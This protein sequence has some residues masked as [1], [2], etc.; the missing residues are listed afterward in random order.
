MVLVL[1][2]FPLIIIYL[3]TIH[4]YGQISPNGR[5][6]IDRENN[7]KILFSTAPEQP[8]VGTLSILR[9]AVQDL[10]TGKPIANLFAHVLI[11]GANSTNQEAT[12]Q[13]N[14][15]SAVDGDFSINVIFRDK[16][17][18]Q[19]ITKITSSSSSSQTY[20]VAL[21]ASFMVVVVPPIQPAMNL[22][23][24]NYYYSITWIGLLIAT[25]VGVGSFLILKNKGFLSQR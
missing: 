18:Y 4:T 2:A 23:D 25:A 17:S 20:D 5:V 10:Q 1:A 24:G 22:S 8:T 15:I 9:F 3:Y 13:L 11:F 14:N 19:V 6:W 7:M 16:G 21:L 12:F